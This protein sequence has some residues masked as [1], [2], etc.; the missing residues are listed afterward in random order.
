MKLPDIEID[1]TERCAPFFDAL[2]DGRLTTQKCGSC[3][4]LTSYEWPRC[5]VCNGDDLTAQDVSGRGTLATWTIID[6]PTHPAFFDLA[7]YVAAYVELDEG[8][9]IPARIDI[10]RAALRPGLPV[11]VRVETATNGTPYPVFAP[12]T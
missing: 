2:A 12:I 11:Q 9:W 4:E 8:P 1:V 3:G 10:E 6:R 5:D 7:P